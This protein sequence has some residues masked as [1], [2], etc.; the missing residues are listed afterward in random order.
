MA[1]FCGRRDICAVFS[2][3]PACEIEPD[4]EPTDSGHRGVHLQVSRAPGHATRGESAEAFG[5]ASMSQNRASRHRAARYFHGDWRWRPHPFHLRYGQ[6]AFPLGATIKSHFLKFLDFGDS[7]GVLELYFFRAYVFL[8]VLG[9]QFCQQF[10]VFKSRHRIC[11]RV[12]ST[13]FVSG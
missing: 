11:T 6:V 5:Q 13:S 12:S 9:M 3:L 4:T 1:M 7:F 8:H 10:R 2:A